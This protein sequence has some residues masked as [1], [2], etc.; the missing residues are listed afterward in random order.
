MNEDEIAKAV[1]TNLPNIQGM[2]IFKQKK[3]TPKIK[4]LCY[5]TKRF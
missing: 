1:K 2:E 5:K 3:L 4:P